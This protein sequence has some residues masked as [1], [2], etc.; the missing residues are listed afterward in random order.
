MK[1]KKIASLMLAGIMAVSMLA[2]CGEGKG[3]SNSGSSSSEQTVTTV[4]VA[5]GANAARSNYAKN[6]LKLT[7]VESSSL[8]SELEKVAASVYKKSA[9]VES[10]ADYSAASNAGK[11]SDVVSGLEGALVGPFGKVDAD[12]NDDRHV[13]HH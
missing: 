6:S 10:I 12:T 9:D 13:E 1:L 7:Y 2:A 4:G 11:A 5:D 3:N 8:A